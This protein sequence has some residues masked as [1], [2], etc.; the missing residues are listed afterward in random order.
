MLNMRMY[1]SICIACI[2]LGGMSLMR[3]W[4]AGNILITTNNILVTEILYVYFYMYICH[5]NKILI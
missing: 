3:L 1:N 4:M 5:T 2:S